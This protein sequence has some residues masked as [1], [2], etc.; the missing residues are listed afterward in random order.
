M[1]LRHNYAAVLPAGIQSISPNG[2]GC[3][4]IGTSFVGTIFNVSAGK[5]CTLRKISA[6]E[7]AAVS[8]T[9]VVTKF[10]KRTQSIVIFLIFIHLTVEILQSNPQMFNDMAQPRRLS[11]VSIQ[12]AVSGI[13]DNIPLQ[14]INACKSSNIFVCIQ[15]CL[16]FLSPDLFHD[17]CH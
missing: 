7:R 6:W 15:T 2:S 3:C 8:L 1:F 10:C 13:I 11:E 17:I 9:L 14:A 4:S 16:F 12:S 5:H